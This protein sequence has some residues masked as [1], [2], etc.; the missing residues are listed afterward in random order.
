MTK[1]IVLTLALGL[2]AQAWAKSAEIKS[3]T[4]QN[5][6]ET[7]NQI[8]AVFDKDVANLNEEDANTAFDVSCTPAI[9]G[10][11]N[12]EDT[13]TWSFDFDTDIYQNNLP[14]GTKCSVTL[15]KAFKQKKGIAGRTAFNFQID[16]P[17]V[18]ESYPGDRTGKYVAGILE[19]QI[20]V[21]GF[22]AKID[23]AS[24]KKNVY[25]KVKDI[26]L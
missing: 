12:W 25:F 3:F 26:I 2:S 21:L 24:L 13:K 9:Q 18:L 5:V 10:R 4:P 20:V 8:R 1:S 19:D 11:A 7:T 17:N 16:G 23:E 6:S 14:G 22:D 15:N